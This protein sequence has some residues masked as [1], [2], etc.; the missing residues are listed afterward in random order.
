M[1]RPANFGFNAETAANNAFQSENPDLTPAQVQAEAI[2]E[3]DGFVSKLRAVGVE[4]H[5]FEDTIAPVKPDAI[6]PNNWIT[7]HQDGTVATYP[8]HAKTRRL[9]R[10][11]DI[12]DQ[13]S[14][15]FGMSK[16]VNFEYTEAEERF[17]EGTGSLILDRPNKIAYACLSPRTEEQLLDEFCEQFGY[18]KMVFTAV[19]GSGKAI[20]H[21]NVMMALAVDFVVACLES[22]PDT[23]ERKALK[24]LF[25]A[26]GKT[27]VEISLDQMMSFAGNM[28]QV[29]GTDDT[30]Y[31]IMSE[32]AYQSLREE[33]VQLIEEHSKILHTPLYTI[34]QHGGGSARCMMAEIFLNKR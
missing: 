7:F 9:E 10:R 4:V 6:F 19:D 17:L 18:K 32:Q 30:P 1:V 11:S 31:L 15:S 26:T 8:M 33:Q 5:V 13:L 27:I 2:A 28:M 21:T 25:E 34:E 29:S 14:E 22:V 20:Y 3:F 23:N 16:R 12:I 24:D